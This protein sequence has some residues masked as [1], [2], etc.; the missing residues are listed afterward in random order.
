MSA[1][2]H[3]AGAS[4]VAALLL[5]DARTPTGTYAHS[6]GLEAAVAHGLRASEVQS[7]IRGRLHTVA[8]TEAAISAVA[9]RFA[10]QDDL[11]R[12]LSLDLEALA[13]ATS[14]A[15]RA[16]ATKLGRSLL[17]TGAQV[18][19]ERAE[20][21]SGY[22]RLSSVTPRPV[23]FGVVSAAG[24]LTPL[25]AATTSLYDDA[26]TV[27]SAS[28]KLLA[29]DAAAATRWV[30][31]LAGDVHALAERAAAALLA[32]LPAASAPLI[33]QRSLSHA[34]NERRLFVT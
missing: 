2:V 24:G 27:A 10:G 34:A 3:D 22:A 18:F 25:Q 14:Q 12:L 13:R 16:A 32:D 15:L 23:A 30:A 19:P 7:F 33:E 8:L 5:A 20:L 6:G 26:A 29:L 9:L 17:R 31:A 11:D 4:S 1:Y 28:V 21:I